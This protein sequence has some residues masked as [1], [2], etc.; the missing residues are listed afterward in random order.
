[1]LIIAIDL[2]DFIKSKYT[3][4]HIEYDG[5]QHYMVIG[6]RNDTPEKLLRRQENDNIKNTEIPKHGIRLIRIPYYE[7]LTEDYIANLL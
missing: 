3:K 6:G 7:K 2:G 4:E 1:M 5:E